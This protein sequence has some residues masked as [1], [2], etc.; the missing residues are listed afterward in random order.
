MPSVMATCIGVPDIEP[1]TSAMHTS[2][3]R[4]RGLLTPADTAASARTSATANSASPTHAVVQPRKASLTA[5][6]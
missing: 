4:P 1:E 2:R 5:S 3:E 6:A